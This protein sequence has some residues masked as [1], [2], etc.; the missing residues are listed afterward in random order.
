MPVELPRSARERGMTLVEVMIA[1]IVL[2]VGI[3][4]IARLFP[5]ATQGQLQN[6]MGTTASYYVQEKIEQ[7]NA[8]TWTDASLT[9]GRHPTATTN[10]NLGTSGAWQRYWVVTTKTGAMS[11]LKQVTVTVTW[12]FHGNRSTSATTY[13]RR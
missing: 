8:L 4:A 10:E 5:S 12:T 6:R 11:A 2:S 7:L 13:I 1:L 9:A 3:L